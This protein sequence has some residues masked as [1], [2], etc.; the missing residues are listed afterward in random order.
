[1][2]R[3]I[4]IYG[5]RCTGKTTLELNFRQAILGK[6]K[7]VQD[8]TFDQSGKI[9]FIGKTCTSVQKKLMSTAGA[10]RIH[11]RIE[12]LPDAEVYFASV[13]PGFD[14]A[15]IVDLFNEIEEVDVICTWAWGEARTGFYRKRCKEFSGTIT[16]TVLNSAKAIHPPILHA[17]PYECNMVNT[18]LL[19]DVFMKRLSEVERKYDENILCRSVLQSETS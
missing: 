11:E 10:E 7:C 6:H 17:H 12:K 9:C 14:K 18:N 13:T 5:R 8:F 19:Y 4:L 1:M 15:G 16:K 3:A 2:A